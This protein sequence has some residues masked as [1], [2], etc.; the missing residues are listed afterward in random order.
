MDEAR[1]ALVCRLNDRLRRQHQ[2][3]RIVITA[4]V[5]ALGAEFLEAALAAVAAFEGFNA[6]NDPYGEH[7]C[8]GLDVAGH[9][10]LFKIDAYDTNLTAGSPDP[11]DPE[12]TTRVLT[13]MLAEEY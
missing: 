7:D 1:R 13:I 2:G 5:H 12:L 4:G 10:V 11:A 6:D 3:G 8:A 9:R